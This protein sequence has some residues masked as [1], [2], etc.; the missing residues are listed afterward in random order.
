MSILAV[1]GAAIITAV[2]ALLLRQKSL[3][4]ALLLSIASGTVIMLSLLRD[5]PDIITGV[6]ALLGSAGIDGGDIIL[7]FKIVGICFVTEFTCDCVSE[8]GLLSLS[9]NISFAGKILV[10]VTSLPM[11]ERVIS[12]I[13]ELSG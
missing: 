13:Q 12:V 3:H 1:C 4:S 8:A 7:L 6:N 9:T 2:M 10:L 5:I 11:F